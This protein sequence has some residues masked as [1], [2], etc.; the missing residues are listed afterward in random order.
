MRGRS[1][2]D[3][4]KPLKIKRLAQQHIARC[5]KSFVSFLATSVSA[6]GVEM[7]SLFATA[8]ANCAAAKQVAQW[9]V[10]RL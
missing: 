4:A 1:D 6:K 10:N 3:Q 9:E 7:A 2:R 5:G 8:V